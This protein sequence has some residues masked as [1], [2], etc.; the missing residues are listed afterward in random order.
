MSP[1]LSTHGAQALYCWGAGALGDGVVTPSGPPVPVFA[2]H[3]VVSV[4][5]SLSYTRPSHV[6]VV[7]TE[8]ETWCWGPNTSGELG[9]PSN[10][11]GWLVPAP[12]WAP[13][14]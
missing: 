14:P 12:V 13:E 3:G 5:V 10:P 7:T 4:A 1:P 9:N 6:C 2:G 11:A 8:G